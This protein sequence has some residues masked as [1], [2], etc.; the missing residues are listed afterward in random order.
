VSAESPEAFAPLLEGS[1]IGYA[2]RTRR[3]AAAFHAGAVA[4][5]GRG[6]LLVGAKGSGKSTLAAYL[7]KQGAEYLSDELALLR[8]DDA[9]IVGFPKSVTVKQGAFHL[10]PE[11]DGAMTHHDPVRGPIRYYQPESKAMIDRPLSLIVFPK[12]TPERTEVHVERLDPSVVALEL[13]RQTFGGLERGAPK[14]L[15]LIGR[16]TMVP[17]YRIELPDCASAAHAIREALND[18][19]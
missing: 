2:V 10:F 3:D 18:A 15:D 4:I 19:P 7:A 8:F 5:D 14:T 16:L 11:L 9:R 6:V 1:L 12:Y 17:G 13:V